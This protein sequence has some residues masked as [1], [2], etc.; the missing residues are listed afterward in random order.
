MKRKDLKW[1]A[2]KVKPALILPGFLMGIA[3]V[4]TLGE[5]NHPP[6]NGKPSWQQ[7]EPEAYVNALDR[8]VLEIKLN[9]G[10]TDKDMGTSHYLHI[11]VNAMFLWWFEAKTDMTGM[12]D[13]H[14]G[15]GNE[16][17]RTSK[18]AFKSTEYTGRD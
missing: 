16:N 5:K 7:V 15:V 13:N 17:T 8:H 2:G 3:K 1:D 10:Q 6:V 18:R 12:D 9:P 14:L 11:A 4:L